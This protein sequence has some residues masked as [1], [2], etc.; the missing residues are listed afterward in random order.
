MRACRA[1]A[2]QRRRREARG[3]S[4]GILRPLKLRDIAAK[5][6]CRLDGDGDLEITR[7]AGIEEAQP[8]DLTFFANPKYTAKVRETRASAVI[9]AEQADVT[10]SPGVARL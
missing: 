6:Q 5:L 2:A 4:A 3:G 9:M 7:I 8:G 1:E 10:T